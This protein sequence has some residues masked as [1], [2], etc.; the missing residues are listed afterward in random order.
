MHVLKQSNLPK[1][2]ITLK[3]WQLFWRFRARFILKALRTIEKQKSIF[4]S[5]LNYAKHYKNR[6]LQKNP[7]IKR[8]RSI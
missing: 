1:V 5:V 4:H 8:Q 3:T 7:G 2:P 6:Y